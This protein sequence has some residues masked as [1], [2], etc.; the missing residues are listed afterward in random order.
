MKALG[1]CAGVLRIAVVL[2]P[3]AVS[4]CATSGATLGS[5]VGDSF[6][7]HPPYYA[8]GDWALEGSSG[9]T[10]HLPIEYQRGSTQPE[11]FDPSVSDAIVALVA[12][13]NTYLDSLEM[14]RRL[15][16]G[17]RVSA[18]AYAPS[19]R[20]PDVQFGCVTL[21][22]APE[23]EC[24]LDG[25]AV[26][27]RGGHGMRLAVGRPS[28]EWTAWMGQVLADQDVGQTLVITLEV[29]QYL[30]RQRGFRGRKE[31]ELGT[32]HTVELP[33]LTS[34][35]T[36]VA[37]VQL[38]GA[39]VRRDGTALRIGAEGLLA[40]RTGI[41]LSGFGAQELVSDDD[42][43]QLRSARREDLPG[44]PL[45]WRVGLRTLVER[46]LTDGEEP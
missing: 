43:R 26:L 45:V 39:L 12:D 29:G 6:L 19:R 37:V 38:T 30:V 31:L 36:P 16:E 13:M 7:E 25:D 10:G 8:E 23:D 1:T 2:A 14:T 46:L 15:V 33:W 34:L 18:V 35:E 27:G 4:A 32:S 17:K 44:H 40:H 11:I 24:A 21:S 22:V 3:A 42:I 5:G 9:L 28:R 20:G 41:V